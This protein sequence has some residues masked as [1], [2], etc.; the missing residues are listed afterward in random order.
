LLA[1]PETEIRWFVCGC[2]PYSSDERAIAAL[3]RVL[4]EDTSAR[5]RGAAA[6]GL[7]RLG[8]PAAIPTLLTALNSDHE[9]DMHVHS[10]SS[11]S[12]TALE[13]IVG[14]KATR[15]PD[16]TSDL[17]MLRRLSS[18]LFEQWSSGRA[19]PADCVPPR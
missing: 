1:D 6:W 11:Q 9:P 3:I 8:S 10:A 14:T 4:R 13:K 7:G 12:A 18:N 5:V 17:E 19:Q 16:G 2:L 15:R